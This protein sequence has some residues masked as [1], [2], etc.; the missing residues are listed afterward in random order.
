MAECHCRNAVALLQD[1]VAAIELEISPHLCGKWWAALDENLRAHSQV[2]T[3]LE[4]VAERLTRQ[5]PKSDY[6]KGSVTLNDGKVIEEDIL[7]EEAKSPERLL[8]ILSDIKEDRFYRWYWVVNNVLAELTKVQAENLFHALVK[9]GKSGRDISGLINK[10]HELGSV[11]EAEKYALNALGQ[12]KPHGWSYS[13]DGGSR[14]EPYKTLIKVD[15]KYHKL[16]FKQ[17]VDDYLEGNRPYHLNTV[18]D[19]L[20]DVFWAQPPTEEIWKE[21]SEHFFQLREFANPAIKLPEEIELP[22][23]GNYHH[24]DMGSA[25]WHHSGSRYLHGHTGGYQGLWWCVG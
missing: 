13:Y 14:I 20:V 11:T 12:S 5:K 15:Q 16:A 18:L 9:L 17:F 25:F 23:G 8:E 22:R 1:L 2:Q 10:L 7:L 21:I 3:L 4:V 24:F 6:T 19:D